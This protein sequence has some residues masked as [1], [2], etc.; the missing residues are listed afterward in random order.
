MKSQREDDVISMVG[1]RLRLRVC[2]LIPYYPRLTHPTLQG[3]L[4]EPVWDSQWDYLT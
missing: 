4:P 1:A 2:H 3:F